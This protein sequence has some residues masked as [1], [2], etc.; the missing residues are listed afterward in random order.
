MTQ[1]ILSRRPDTPDDRARREAKVSGL[2]HDDDEVLG[3]AYDA[4]LVRRL[5]QFADP[6]RRQFLL[7]VAA[8]TVATLMSV[9]GP[10]VIGRAV[11]A[12]LNS[13]DMSALRFWTLIFAAVALTEWFFN[14]RAID[15]WCGNEFVFSA[16]RQ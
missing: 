2:L 8:M 9:A 3:R 7:A 11:D 15:S 5:W 1:T 14:R 6:Y 12:G 10:W 4:R 13:T 16:C